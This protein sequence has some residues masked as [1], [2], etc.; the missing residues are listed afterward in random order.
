M[1]NEKKELINLIN[2]ADERLIRI[3]VAVAK[4]YNHTPA[5]PKEEKLYRLVY[6]SARSPK[7]DE[8][9]IEALEAI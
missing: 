9:D 8:K 3:M 7:C 1:E 4:E 2:G 5:Q 6:T